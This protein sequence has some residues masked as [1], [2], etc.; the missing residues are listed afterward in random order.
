MEVQRGLAADVLPI[1][2]E[3]ATRLV[4]ESSS[5]SANATLDSSLEPATTQAPSP[6]PTALEVGAV[7]SYIAAAA[8][9]APLLGLFG[10]TSYRHR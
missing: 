7:G 10:H 8:A 9:A 6:P 4:H 2:I 5:T 3:H 1:A